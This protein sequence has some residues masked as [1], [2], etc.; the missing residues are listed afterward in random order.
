[1]ADKVCTKCLLPK[2]PSEFSANNRSKD[3]KHVW[4]KSCVASYNRGRKTTA[5]D[6]LRIKTTHR[7]SK[8][9]INYQLSVEE[10]EAMYLVQEGRCAICKREHT[11][12]VDHN[13]ETGKV[14]GLLCP[15]CNHGLGRF[16]DN[17][18]VLQ[19]AIEYLRKDVSNDG[20]S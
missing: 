20:S 3:G 10:Y 2:D 13:H 6:K 8:L 7:K 9:K 15:G 16:R 5:K 12:V 11:L 17:I 18:D 19:S 14:R 4:C 1:M